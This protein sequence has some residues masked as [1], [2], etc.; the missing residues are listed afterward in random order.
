M[1]YVYTIYQTYTFRPSKHSSSQNGPQ[2]EKKKQNKTKSV[3][4]KRKSLYYMTSSVSGQDELNPALAVIG[5]PRGQDGTILPARDFLFC[6][7]PNECTKVFFRK[8]FP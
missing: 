1:D 7:R 3:N 4:D 2:S 8:Y 5:C 6:S